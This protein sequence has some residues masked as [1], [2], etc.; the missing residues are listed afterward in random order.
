MKAYK[1][2][3][4]GGVQGVGYRKYILDFAQEYGLSEL[5]RES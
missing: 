3:V 1:I 2:R 4:Y 5:Y